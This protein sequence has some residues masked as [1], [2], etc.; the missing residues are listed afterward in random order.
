[1][2][3]GRESELKA[4]IKQS[5]DCFIRGG[6]MYIFIGFLF[7]SIRFNNYLFFNLKMRF[8]DSL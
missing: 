1:M 2:L 7:D 3:S 4:F 5:K 8:S 6:G